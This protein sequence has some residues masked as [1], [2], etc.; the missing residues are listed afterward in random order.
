MVEGTPFQETSVYLMPYI[1]RDNSGEIIKVSARMF[2][3]GEPSPHNNHEVVAFLSNRGQD[4]KD[5]EVALAKLAQ[6]DGEMARA[7]EDLILILL[8]KNMV[9]MT[10]LPKEVQ[11]RISFRVKQRV[12]IQDIY[13]QASARILS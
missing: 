11:D 5:I 12:L 3:G 9:K 6:T 1:Q 13:D 10:E 7:V 4:P 2:P 8:K